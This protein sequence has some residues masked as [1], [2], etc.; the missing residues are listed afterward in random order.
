MQQKTEIKP[1]LLTAVQ[2]AD[3][4][5]MSIRSIR[6]LAADGSL[7]QPVRIG[8]MVRWNRAAVLS[9]IERGCSQ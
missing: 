9:W 4:L 5:Q 6:R 8:R 1:E 3:L 2:L 7:P